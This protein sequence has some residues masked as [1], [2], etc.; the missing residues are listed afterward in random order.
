MKYFLQLLED[1]KNF[2][3]QF[4]IGLIRGNDSMIASI[5]RRK[6]Y[7]TKC[8]IDTNVF[9]KN[10][11]N[12]KAG[13]DSCLY[14]S[15]YILNS[16]GKFH[17]GN[18][19]HLGAFCYVN[20]CYGKVLIGENVAIGPGTKII[21]YSNH[22]ERGKKVTDVRKTGDVVIGNNVFIGA[23]CTILSGTVIHDNV[24]VAAGAVIKSELETNAIYGGVPGKLIKRGWYE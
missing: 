22:Y 21:A 14:H 1:T 9:I 16:N 23:N 3:W 11:N 19:S 8:F 6:I 13:Q 7:R 17:I 4:V 15:C 18:N 24:I 12:F 10:R 20:V 2:L 5:L